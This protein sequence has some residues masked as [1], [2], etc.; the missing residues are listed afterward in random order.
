M[1]TL[2]INVSG[3]DSSVA[4]VADGSLRF[5]LAQE[6]LSRRK[7]DPDFPFEAV[8]AALDSAG[9]RLD[10]VD[11]VGMSCPFDGLVMLNR[12]RLVLGGKVPFSWFNVRDPVVGLVYRRPVR[13]AARGLGRPVAWWS[14]HECHALWGAATAGQDDCA[15]LVVDE[16]GARSA[17]TIWHFRR[18]RLRLRHRVDY[19]NSLGLFYAACTQHLGFQPL[20]DE[21][22]VMGLAAYGSPGVDVSPLLRVHQDGYAVNGR[23][24]HG[25][26]TGD[27][28]GAAAILGPPRQPGQEI[29]D[30]HRDIAFAVQDA[31]ERAVLALAGAA[32]RLTG[33]ATLCVVGGVALNC[34]ANGRIATEGRFRQVFVPPAAGDDGS[35]AGA[36]LALR[37]HRSGLHSNGPLRDA[38]L[39]Q[40]WSP[41]EVE[42]L[43]STC[44]LRFRRVL[45]PAEV[46]AAHLAEGRVVARFSGRSEFGA[47]ALGAR[48]ILAHPGD[49]AMRDR[50][51][52]AVKYREPWRPFAPVVLEEVGGQYFAGFCAAPFMTRTFQALPA[53][54]ERAP[55]VVHADGT[56]RVQSV[57]HGDD[58]ELW[59]VLRSFQRRT[60]LPILLNTSFNLRGEPIVDSPKDA[61][62]TFYTSGIDVLMLEC[63]EVTK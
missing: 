20:S 32:H 45:E 7:H 37:Y 29:T 21:W 42:A 5:A 28:S 22:K 48:S 31:T 2:G 15:I 14:H 51:N 27:P 39:G 11:A 55:A 30:R 53:A 56:A 36:A 23:V 58:P 60:G 59:R 19:P 4:L 25:L 44:G 1:L 8:A 26:Y 49:P 35:A 6:R 16:K 38:R 50:L 9:A 52:A 13:L 10:D 3:H 54:R 33:S 17:T 34:K 63:F 46:T 41:E 18:G 57:A 40:S 12:L 61:L 47:R 24:L 43:L 62:R